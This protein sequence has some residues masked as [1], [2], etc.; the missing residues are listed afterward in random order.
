MRL[1]QR[2]GAKHE[3]IAVRVV[4]PLE[5]ALPKVGELRLRDP[6]TGQ[7]VW[8]DTSDKNLRVAY[9][10]LVLE[11][12]AFIERAMRLARVDMLELNTDKELVE[13]LLKFTLQRRA[14]RAL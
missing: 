2:L 12:T 14:R 9:E 8:I 5:K 3:L 1:L 11:Q 4:D 13:P 6:E 10:K 7:E